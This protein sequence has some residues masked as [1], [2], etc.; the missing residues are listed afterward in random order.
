MS[1]TSTRF[2]LWLLVKKMN[3]EGLL[4]DGT[5]IEGAFSMLIGAAANPYMKPLELNIIR[6][7]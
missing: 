5:K 7:S 6:L 4:L 2:S 1:L 3:D